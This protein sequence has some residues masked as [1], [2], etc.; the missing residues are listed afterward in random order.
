MGRSLAASW[1]GVQLDLPL[2]TVTVERL[3]K[4]HAA[5]YHSEVI[6]RASGWFPT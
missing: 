2:A 4:E 1:A 6:L 5:W 3:S